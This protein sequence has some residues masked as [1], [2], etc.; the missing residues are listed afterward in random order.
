MAS[1][2][3]D[4][5]TWDKSPAACPAARL[6]PLEGRWHFEGDVAATAHGPASKWTSEEYCS[7]LPGKRFL[8][9]Q[10]DAKVGEREFRGM[11]VFGHDAEHGYFATFYD[12]IGNHP[13]YEI[14]LDGGTW[15]LGGEAQRATYQFERDG[16]SVRIRWETNEGG[17]WKPLC[18]LVGT[19]ITAH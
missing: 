11:A 6:A 18:E 13:T 8:V 10:W 4:Q 2:P 5:P 15:H 19:R 3:Q 1:S 16:S 14:H 12:N 7:W 17:N 9:N